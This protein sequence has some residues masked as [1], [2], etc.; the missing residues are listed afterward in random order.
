MLLALVLVVSV[1]GETA[2][3]AD[4]GE[5]LGGDAVPVDPTNPD[6]SA[7][8][9]GFP[10][11]ST[12]VTVTFIVEAADEYWSE[13]GNFYD[14]FDI[15]LTADHLQLFSISDLLVEV[16]NT[17]PEYELYTKQ[18]IGAVPFTNSSDYLYGVN[19]DSTLFQPE[20]FDLWG[21]VFRINDLFPVELFVPNNPTPGDQYLRGTDVFHTFIR[22]GDVIH[23]YWDYPTSERIDGSDP[24]AWFNYTANYIRIV[25]EVVS[26]SQI[27]VQLQSHLADI[28]PPTMQMQVWNYVNFT[29]PT[30]VYLYDSSG[31]VLDVG[32]T[33]AN[34]LVTFSG[35]F[36]GD[37]LLKTRSVLLTND[38]NNNYNGFFFSQTSGYKKILVASL[39][40]PEI[41]NPVFDK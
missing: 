6:E 15:T 41:P 33:D 11:P 25:P 18:G 5:Y 39:L 10:R 20:E 38:P 31:A 30:D 2:F 8:L 4:P 19:H 16:E 29:T 27:T 26:D 24:P 12:E 7:F 14:E 22:N 28:D 9:A 21:W 36:D 17:H 1:F 35:D 37:Y 32:R 34:G 13:E 3:A 23:F 40:L